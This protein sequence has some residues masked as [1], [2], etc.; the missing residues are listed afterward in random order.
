MNSPI[1]RLLSRFFGDSERSTTLS[2][3]II[4]SLFLK[5]ISIVVQLM[6]VP[7]TLTYLSKELY[8]IWLT[9]SSVV[10]WLTFF[11]VGFSLGLKNRLA[12]AIA[13]GNLKRGKQL[14]S[15]TYVMLFAIF[16]PLG[17]ICEIIIPFF[18]W[19]KILNVAASYGPVLVVTMR[20]LILSFVLQMMFNTL[21]T[22]LAAFQRVAFANVFTVL[23][24]V[25][26]LIIIWLL[27]Q[28]TEP[29]L[30][31]MAM[32]ISFV[33]VAIYIVSS[34]ILFSGPLRAVRPSLLAF[35]KD[36]IGDIFSLGVK[37][38]I[39][40][41]Q[42]II[43][44]QATNLLISNISNPD[45]VAYYNIVYRYLG[46]AMMVFNLVL[47]P[48]WPAFTDAYTKGD[49][50]WM[51]ST[52][53]TLTRLYLF[54]LGAIIIMCIISPFAYAIWLGNTISIPWAMT[55]SI[56][57]YFIILMWDSLQANL[58]NGIG[59]VK[60]QSYVTC[61]GI[62]FHIPLSFFLGHY[63]G[64]YGVVVSLTLIT[65]IYATCLTIQSIKIL[66][67]KASG[68]WAK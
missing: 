29:S 54:C 61:V 27:I 19:T 7:M 12:E 14:V 1:S 46:A 8:G 10:L 48:L 31:N 39:I 66:Q 36:A 59:A 41:I 25:V 55:I 5:G 50:V 68:I 47:A 23:G 9:I 45:F 44:Q 3:N 53:R 30:I 24:N 63:I 52:Y 2:K 6:L 4:G 38:F 15:T 37:F 43:M 51:R 57:V 42:L 20:I 60:L 65:F 22:I 67:K 49:Y 13:K 33:P 16:V 26:S 35:R 64:A 18:D 11:D 40:Q 21:S 62:V 28:F 34:L 17:L 58:I 56:A 32:T